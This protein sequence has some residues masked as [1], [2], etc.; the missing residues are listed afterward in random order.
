MGHRFAEIAFTDSVREVQQQLGSRAGY[1]SLDG[2]EDFN[3]LLGERE[4]GF[5]EVAES[6]VRHDDLVKEV[7]IASLYSVLG[8][9]PMPTGSRS[10]IQVS[11][12]CS[13]PREFQ[14]FERKHQRSS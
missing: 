2:G 12:S 13:V 8:V 9:Q 14:S 4:A 3:H 10:Y 6:S 11:C 5:I 1:A 7:V